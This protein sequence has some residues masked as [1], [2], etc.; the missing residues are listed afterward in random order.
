MRQADLAKAIPHCSSPGVGV[1]LGELRLRSNTCGGSISPAQAPEFS[2]AIRL[3][4]VE[5][6]SRCAGQPVFELGVGDAGNPGQRP[7]C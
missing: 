6:Q 3:T 4:I 5:A 1:F 2:A 7:P